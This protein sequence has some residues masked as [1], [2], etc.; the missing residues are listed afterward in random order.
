MKEKFVVLFVDENVV[1][2]IVHEELSVSVEDNVVFSK[3]L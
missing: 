3:G 2:Q 1:K